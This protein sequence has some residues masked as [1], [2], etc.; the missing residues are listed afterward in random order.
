[1]PPG[2]GEVCRRFRCGIN[3]PESHPSQTSAVR[4]RP[5]PPYRRFS[6]PDGIRDVPRIA[7]V[8]QHA[9]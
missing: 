7:M 8:D 2:P 6:T 5:P 4:S 9:P 1:M 3:S